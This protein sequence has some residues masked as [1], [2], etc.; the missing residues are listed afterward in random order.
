MKA[1]S[2]VTITDEYG[3]R[4]SMIWGPSKTC[5]PVHREKEERPGGMDQTDRGSFLSPAHHLECPQARILEVPLQIIHGQGAVV[6]AGKDHET[7]KTLRRVAKRIE[8]P[9]V[10]AAGHQREEP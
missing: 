1:L 3:R 5:R 7:P 2:L 4:D 9:Q 6:L 10:R 8:P